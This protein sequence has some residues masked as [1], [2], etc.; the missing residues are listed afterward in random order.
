MRLSARQTAHNP[1]PS[2]LRRSLAGVAAALLIAT[3]PS[4]VVAQGAPEGRQWVFGLGTFLTRDRGWNYA[5][6]LEVGVAVER[7]L[8]A[9]LRLSLGATGLASLESGGDVPAVFPPFPD[10]LERAAAL[11]LQVR[12]KTRGAGLY[13]MAG[14]EALAGDAGNQG[15]G[16]R[17]GASVGSGW[18]WQGAAR[19]AIE[20]QYV[21]FN[22]P[23]GTTRGLLSVRFVHRR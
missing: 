19:S 11:R 10:G 22:Q 14:V 4:T 5:E 12:T 23:F 16:A 8:G 3:A 20:G 9:R 2:S 17:T 7:D 21:V 1:V 18:S 6:G 15:R 13:A